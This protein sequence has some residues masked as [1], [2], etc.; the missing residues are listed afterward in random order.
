[1][2]ILSSGGGLS[3][4]TFAHSRDPVEC[5]A[6][7]RRL[8]DLDAEIPD[9]RS[10][11]WQATAVPVGPLTILRGRNGGWTLRGA[12]RG[13][14]VAFARGPAGVASAGVDLEL[15]PGV[16]GAVLSA[17]ARCELRSPPGSGA[18]MVI[19]DPAFVAAQLQSL[20]GAAPG[21]P[22]RALVNHLSPKISGPPPVVCGV[23]SA[24]VI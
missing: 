18:T 12:P 3:R 9:P 8:G 4:F 13:H 5:R 10:F 7:L 17:G 24:G 1:M 6:L 14:A 16:G 23:R 15:V 2:D 21:A 19:L 22:L 11:H 20:A